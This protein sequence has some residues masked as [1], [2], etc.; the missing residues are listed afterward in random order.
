MKISHTIKDRL[1]ADC[2]HRYMQWIL[3][4][5][6]DRLFQ[7]VSLEWSSPWCRTRRRIACRRWCRT[8]VARP[9]RDQCPQWRWR[10]RGRTP[11]QTRT[12][13]PQRCRSSSSVPRDDDGC[14]GPSRRFIRY[15]FRHE[16]VHNTIWTIPGLADVRVQIKISARDRAR[17]DTLRYVVCVVVAPRA[18]E[19]RSGC[20]DHSRRPTGIEFSLY[21][22][23]YSVC[24]CMLRAFNTGTFE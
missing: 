18:V 5:W 6:N 11:A 4:T 15:V 3:L 16:N 17:T 9:R 24:V 10:P 21:Y 20:V 14:A 19:R 13:S 12:I 23:H 2:Q 8:V 1:G 7:A 22:Y